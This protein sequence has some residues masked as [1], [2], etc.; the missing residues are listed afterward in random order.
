[1]RSYFR[2]REMFQD[3]L[4]GQHCTTLRFQVDH[5]Q[6][7]WHSGCPVRPKKILLRPGRGPV[8]S[9]PNTIMT[10]S[11]KKKVGMWDVWACVVLIVQECLPPT[12]TVPPQE[13][14][15][16]K[17]YQHQNT[18]CSQGTEV[19][20]KKTI[21]TWN[22]FSNEFRPTKYSAFIISS[23]LTPFLIYH[24]QCLSDWSDW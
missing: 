6:G 21:T 5:L 13:E 8:T 19:I 11:A 20:L 12:L 9:H 16:Q 18:V 4:S 23:S 14:I 24:H 2:M 15:H 1:M 7:K 10:I 22:C 3:T 17:K